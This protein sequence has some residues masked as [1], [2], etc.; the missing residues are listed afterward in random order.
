MVLGVGISFYEH[1]HSGSVLQGPNGTF[2]WLH[3]PYNVTYQKPS[4]THGPYPLARVIWLTR[5]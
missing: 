4:K 1:G 3:I 2:S 5:M